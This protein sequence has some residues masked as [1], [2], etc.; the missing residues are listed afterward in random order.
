MRHWLPS[1]PGLPY[2]ST[3]AS[4]VPLATSAGSRNSDAMKSS[5]ESIRAPT[6]CSDPRPS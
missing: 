4:T 3:K 1:A 6:A 2:K 5:G